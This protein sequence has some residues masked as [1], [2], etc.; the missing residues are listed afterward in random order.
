MHR[1]GDAHEI[2]ALL[3]EWGD[4]VT[5]FFRSEELVGGGEEGEGAEA[6]CGHSSRVEGGDGDA[7]VGVG[8]RGRGGGG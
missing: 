8:S 3:E 6:D 7:G 5:A 1:H 2:V 4:E